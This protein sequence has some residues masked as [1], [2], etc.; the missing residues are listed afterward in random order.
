[1]K[2]L[3]DSGHEVTLLNRANIDDGFGDKIDR[4]KCD[5]RHTDSLKRA[6]EFR[7]WDLV[8]DQACFDFH[9]A[10]TAV[11]I[12]RDK[13]EKYIMTSSQ[14]V[15]GQGANLKEGDFNPKKY[16]LKA[17]KSMQEDYAEA[18]RQAEWAFFTKASFPVVAVRF[19]IVIGS[20][21]PTQRIQRHVKRV[22]Q[23]QP[24]YF[25]NLDARIS[26]IY[27]DHAAQVLA[28]LSTTSFEGSLNVASPTAVSLEEFLS[29]V[30]AELSKNAI[31]AETRSEEAHSPYGIESDW[32][33]NCERLESLGMR[34]P[35][36][37]EWLP[38]VI[39]NVAKSVGPGQSL[40]QI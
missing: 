25:P 38:S 3:L 28:F 24:L 37:R 30:Q 5:R 6:V 26:F 19:P 20:N 8:Y 31:L 12:F 32:Y 21:D 40:A 7:K 35:E 34:L 13:V 14:S 9:D 39:K 17:F 10:S 23:N 2:S 36:I 4:I 33:M 22:M 15:Y 11:D 18:K 1:M 29:Y 16:Q 27:R